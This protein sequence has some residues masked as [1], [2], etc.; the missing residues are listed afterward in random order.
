MAKRLEMK[1]EGEIWKSWR[2]LHI[3]ATDSAKLCGKSRFGDIHDVWAEKM[4]GKE[5]QENWYMQRGKELEPI[6]RDFLSIR[7]ETKLEPACFESE[8]YFFMGVSMDAVDK[9]NKLAFEIK[10]C[11]T[12]KIQELKDTEEVEEGYVYQCQ[13]QMLV[14]GLEKMIIF[15]ADRD[16]QEINLDSG[17]DSFMKIVKR[18]ETIIKEIIEADKAFWKML[19]DETPPK[20]KYIEMELDEEEE[21][22]ALQNEVSDK[23]KRMEEL[24]NIL[25][26]KAKETGSDV[27]GKYFTIFSQTRKKT[28]WNSVCK[29][30]GISTQDLREFNSFSKTYIVK[31]INFGK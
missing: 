20:P 10:T 13:K 1:Q 21:L 3:T 2:R 22:L 31:K 15:F 30:W 18:D 25:R 29:K 19:V 27:K 23:V 28:N 24:K 17:E 12:S 26:E 11:S 5:I 16:K 6:I 7:F 8:E 9:S 4:E 14:L